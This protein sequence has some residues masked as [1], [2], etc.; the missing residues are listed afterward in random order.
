MSEIPV[1]L[2]DFKHKS[3]VLDYFNLNDTD[4]LCKLSSVV[5]DGQL[6][7]IVDV[8]VVGFAN[9][10]YVFGLIKSVLSFKGGKS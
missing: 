9:D 6:F 5:I 3:T 4:L 8:I 1:E 7:R 2:L 10:E